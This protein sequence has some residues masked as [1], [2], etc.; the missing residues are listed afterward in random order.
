MTH[1]QRI[2]EAL[3]FRETSRPPCHV[4]LTQQAQEQLCAHTGNP[5]FAQDCM[6]N[7]ITMIAYDGFLHPVAGKQELFEDDFGVLWDRSGVD[8][9]VGVV[10]RYQIA[11]E[12]DYDTYKLPPV[13][14]AKIRAMFEAGLAQAGDTFVLG[15]I[16]FSLFER[17][18]SLRGMENLLMDMLTEPERVQQLLEQICEY[19]LKIMEIAFEYPLDGFHFGDDWGQQRGLIMGPALWRKFIRP[20][21]QTLYARAHEKGLWVTQHSCGDLHEVLDDLVEIGLNAYNTVQP[22]IYDLGALKQKYGNKLTF[23]GGIST[24]RDLASKMQQEITAIT[25]E[26]LALMSK[27]GGYIAAPTHAIE[28][29]VPPEN[30]LAMLN[31]FHT[32]GA[33]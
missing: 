8:K 22:E 25:R 14:E 15:G 7:H 10:A 1:K 6:D 16:G 27:G 17:A 11:T 3:S 33:Q 26:T 30:I 18:W 2:I 20:Q 32:F 5:R 19:N 4:M 28:F 31:V 13:P 29:D 9:D 21:M 24:Q 12:E 23:W